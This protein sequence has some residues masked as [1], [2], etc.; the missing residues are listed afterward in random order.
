[1][2]ALVPALAGALVVAGVL[3]LLVIRASSEW[4]SGVS[5]LGLALV[6]LLVLMTLRQQLVSLENERLARARLDA[7][8]TQ[9]GQE[10]DT[11][12]TEYLVGL[13]TALTRTCAESGPLGREELR[14]LD[15][16][17]RQWRSDDPNLRSLY[18]LLQL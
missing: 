13:L 5:E 1:M 11:E 15:H 9:V 6:L 10:V 16:Y 17:A 3:A 4:V 18:A 8:L 7:L 14:R 12:Q 2:T